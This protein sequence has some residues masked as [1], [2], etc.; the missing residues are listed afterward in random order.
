MSEEKAD[1]PQ[2][3]SQLQPRTARGQFAKGQPGGYVPKARK[4]SQ[5][6]PV[7]KQDEPI[8]LDGFGPVG[9]TGLNRWGGRIHEEWL[10]DLQGAKGIRMYREMSE[11]DPSVQSGLYVIRSLSE[12]ID[13]TVE[14]V[15]DQPGAEDDAEFLQSAVGDMNTGLADAIDEGLSML[16]FGW[17]FLEIVYK[18]RAGSNHEDP[19]LHS[20]SLIHI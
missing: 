9:R 11:G 5:A 3:F 13:W 4:E 19:S 10:K 17:S 7:K 18:L 15:D 1:G 8:A 20:L 16:E 12:G 14:P 2:H 6:E